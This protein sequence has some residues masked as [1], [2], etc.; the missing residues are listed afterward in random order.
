MTKERAGALIVMAHPVFASDRQ[1]LV[2]L[3]AKNRLPAMHHWREFVDAGGLMAY[4]PNL[5]A[6]NRRTAVY[7]DQILK[8]AKPG[9]LPV[10]GPT[11]FE[12]TINARTARALGLTVPRVLVER[13]DYVIQ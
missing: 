8:G 3:A 7:I 9:D 11:K 5:V 4:G 1:K 6:L 10:E 2:D 13:A 12:L